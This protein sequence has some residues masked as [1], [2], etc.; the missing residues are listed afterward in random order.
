MSPS[1]TVDAGEVDHL[2][3]HPLT[4]LFDNCPHKVPTTQFCNACWHEDGPFQSYAIRAAGVLIRQYYTVHLCCRDVRGNLT[5]RLVGVTLDPVERQRDLT[6]LPL[7]LSERLDD[8][9]MPLLRFEA[10]AV[11]I[12]ERRFEIKSH[13]THV[14]SICW[15]CVQV[16]GNALIQLM[17][18][19]ISTDAFNC[20]SGWSELYQAWEDRTFD[21]NHLQVLVS[22]GEESQS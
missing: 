8:G 18:H 13:G 10:G 2:T 22:D 11:R 21:I 19:L 4:S 20:D 9:A 17:Q 5:G 3:N 12:G 7:E 6:P 16:D 1:N 14:G 15:D